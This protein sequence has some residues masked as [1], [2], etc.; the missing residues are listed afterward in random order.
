MAWGLPRFLREATTLAGAK[1]QIKVRMGTRQARFLDVAQRLIYGNSSSPCRR[2][3]LWAGCDYADLEQAVRSNGIEA[4]LAKLRDEGVFLSLE[5]FKARTPICR[6]GL[7]MDTRAAD[8]DNPF[9]MGKGI[10]VTTSGSRSRPTRVA[11][12]WNLMAE[13]AANECLLSEIHGVLQVPLALWLPVPSSVAGISYFLTNAKLRRPLNRWFS[14]VDLASLGL[15]SQN[16]LATEFILAVCRC[17]G[18]AAPR[19]EF[20]DATH[21][22]KV[23]AW[24]AQAKGTA[25]RCLL[26]AY[27]SSA[28]RAARAALDRGLDLGGCVMLTGGEPL[29]ERRRRFIESTGAAAIPRYSATETGLIGAACNHRDSADDMH[30]YMDRLAVIQM[31]RTTRLGG[32]PV[33]AFL[34]SSLSPHT[35]KVLL[36]TDL[37]DFGTLSTRP[38]PCLFG[39]LGLTLRASSV[40][41]HDKLTSEGMSLLG[42]ELDEIIAA[43]VE[44]A[45]G[46]PD[47]YQFWETEDENGFPKLLV[48]VSPS[49]SDLD[50]RR[51]IAEV[52]A[53]LNP[54][55]RG[56]SLT[57]AMWR[58]ANT[59]QLVR[60]EPRL[61]RGQKLLAITKAPSP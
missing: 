16:R 9:L 34:F 7:T 44:Q 27:A 28:V 15:L 51:F 56:G 52:L 47:D 43:L 41:S 42:S 26:R 11:Y 12:D 14:P 45:G 1:E 3:L 39:E 6:K 10:S 57:S 29:T 20:T 60:A 48:A 53:R 23:A 36:N 55:P 31:P 21:A 33:N 49:I 2:L 38:C 46:G 30:I 13:H 5:E 32:P 24:M 8:F 58:Q 22:D 37:G 35:G 61:T 54:N 25:G 17:L 19:P 59:L 4:T 18:H 40:R 50:E